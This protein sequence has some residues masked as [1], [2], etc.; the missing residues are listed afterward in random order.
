M[1]HQGSIHTPPCPTVEEPSL[2]LKVVN[3][4]VDRVTPHLHIPG[5]KEYKVL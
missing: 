5:H 1:A 3:Y 2:L 4:S